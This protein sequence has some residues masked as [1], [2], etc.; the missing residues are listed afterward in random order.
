MGFRLRGLCLLIA[1]ANVAVLQGIQSVGGGQRGGVAQFYVSD[2]SFIALSSVDEED[3]QE[4]AAE[5]NKRQLGGRRYPLSQQGR[6]AND[7]QIDQ[8]AADGL[9]IDEETTPA[10]TDLSGDV[11]ET[12]PASTETSVQEATAA[13]TQPS[14]DAQETTPAAATE[15]SGDVVSVATTTAGLTTAPS[16]S[17]VTAETTAATSPP[18]DDTA[19][20][21]AHASTTSGS[22]AL[23]AF[24]AFETST[25]AASVADSAAEDITTWPPMTTSPEMDLL[26]AVGSLEAAL[27]PTTTEQLLP[28]GGNNLTN[29]QQTHAGWDS[30]DSRSEE[31]TGTTPIGYSQTPTRE[32]KVLSVQ[33]V[34][35]TELKATAAKGDT[36]IHVVDPD[37]FALYDSITVGGEANTINRLV[38][39]LF[40]LSV[41]LSQAFPQGTM[42]IKADSFGEVVIVKIELQNL[43]YAALSTQTD[44]MDR[45][46]DALRDVAAQE[47]GLGRQSVDVHVLA[48][49]L[50]SV[51]LAEAKVAIPIGID[52]FD[53][54][55][56]LASAADLNAAV[57]H[58]VNNIS[59][60][61]VAAVENVRVVSV[62]IDKSSSDD[63]EHRATSTKPPP[64][65]GP[66]VVA[67]FLTTRAASGSSDVFVESTSGFHV[68]DDV[69]IGGERNQ[70]EASAASSTS[71]L[72]QGGLGQSV[73]HLKDALNNSHDAGTVVTNVKRKWQDGEFYSKWDF[74]Y[75]FCGGYEEAAPCETNDFYEAWGSAEELKESKQLCSTSLTQPASHCARITVESTWGCKAGDVVTIGDERHIVEAVI[76]D[77]VITLGTPTLKDWSVGTEVHPANESDPASLLQPDAAVEPHAT[78][79][80]RKAEIAATTQRQ[81]SRT[82][83]SHDSMGSKQRRE[84]RSQNKGRRKWLDGEYYT[85]DQ[86]AIKL[87][88]GQDPA[89]AAAAATA[90][91]E[92]EEAWK[93][94]EREVCLAVL[95]EEAPVGTRGVKV[96]KRGGCFQVGDVVLLGGE[97]HT[98]ADVK[99]DM[100]TFQ[101]VLQAGHQ[102]AST[103]R[104]YAETAAPINA[105]PAGWMQYVD[106]RS[107]RP[108]YVNEE[109]ERRQWTRPQTS[110]PSSLLAESSTAILH[111]RLQQR[112]GLLL[113]FASPDVNMSHVTYKNS[114]VG[115][116][117]DKRR[118]AEDTYLDRASF[119]E[120]YKAE[121][122]AAMGQEVD[123]ILEADFWYTWAT[124]EMLPEVYRTNTSWLS[125]QTRTES[126]ALQESWA[127]LMAGD[128]T[129]EGWFRI[130][131]PPEHGGTLMGS[132]GDGSSSSHLGTNHRR[133]HGSLF[134][135]PDGTIML[136]SNAGR[137]DAD[138]EDYGEDM[139]TIPGPL[140]SDHN[141]HHFAVAW[142]K[143]E[144]KG[145]LYV[146]S[147]LMGSVLYDFEAFPEDLV[148]MDGRL[149]FGGG[150]GLSLDADI[151]QLRLWNRAL[152]TGQLA[153]CR[154]YKPREG[155][156]ALY[157][158][159]GSFRN[160]AGTALNS[161]DDAADSAGGRFVDMISADRCTEDL[162][163]KVLG[164]SNSEACPENTSRIDGDS[165]CAA[166]AL[167]L[168]VQ[169]DGVAENAS[170]PSGCSFLTQGNGSVIFNLAMGSP[171]P[172]YRPICRKRPASALDSEPCDDTEAM[173]GAQVQAMNVAEHCLQADAAGR[174][175]VLVP[176]DVRERS[177]LLDFSGCQLEPNVQHAEK[178]RGRI[179][180]GPKL[181]HCLSVPT[182][183]VGNS[184]EASIPIFKKCS[185][186]DSAQEFFL[187]GSG[188]A[189][190]VGRIRSAWSPTKCLQIVEG[191][192]SSTGRRLPLR[193]ALADCLESSERQFR[194]EL[195][196]WEQKAEETAQ[197][198]QLAQ[199][200]EQEA[201]VRVPLTEAYLQRA[202][203]GMRRQLR[204]A[205]EVEGNLKASEMTLVRK[206][207]ELSALRL[208]AV[209][210]EMA[211]Q[212]NQTRKSVAEARLTHVLGE[213][214]KMPK[215]VMTARHEAADAERQVNSTAARVLLAQERRK[216]ASH[217]LERLQGV[218]NAVN[219]LTVQ[220]PRQKLE[221]AKR[222]LVA[223]RA[224]LL[225]ADRG[226]LKLQES[227]RCHANGAAGY[228]LA[229]V[230]GDLR[231]NAQLACESVY[232]VG[233]CGVA[234]CGACDGKAFHGLGQS[235]V[236]CNG[237]TMWNFANNLPTLGCQWRSCEEV[238]ISEDGRTWSSSCEER[239]SFVD[240]KPYAR[241]TLGTCEAV[242]AVMATAI[243][244]AADVAKSAHETAKASFE[245]AKAA[246]ETWESEYQGKK[247][248]EAQELPEAEA[249]MRHA[250][251]ALL[252]A[253][254]AHEEAT[255]RA[256][257]L[258]SK[259]VTDDALEATQLASRLSKEAAA[260]AVAM[261]KGE[262]WEMSMLAQEEVLPHALELAEEQVSFANRTF[263]EAQAAHE[264]VLEALDALKRKD[265]YE[266]ENATHGWRLAK[267]EHSFEEARDAAFKTSRAYIDAMY[268][269]DVTDREL[270]LLHAEA[271]R[272]STNAT[273][274]RLRYNQLFHI[275]EDLEC[276]S[277]PPGGGTDEERC[278]G[279]ATPEYRYIFSAK[280]SANCPG[281]KGCS[282]LRR[283]QASQCLAPN[284]ASLIEEDMPKSEAC[285]EGPILQHGT[286]CTT[287]CAWGYT[288]SVASL[289]CG[290][291][292]LTPSL[293]ECKGNPCNAPNGIENAAAQ[294]CAEG[295][296]V[297]HGA[298]CTPQCAAGYTASEEYLLCNGSQLEPR[299]YACV[300]NTCGEP[301][302]AAGGAIEHQAAEGPC[303]E[304]ATIASGGQCTARCEPGYHPSRDVLHCL[305]GLLTPAQFVCE[306]DA[307]HAPE[308]I[309]HVAAAGACLEGSSVEEVCTAQC[310]PNYSPS[311]KS[312]KCQGG[313]LE[314]ATFECV[315][316]TCLAPENISD[317]ASVACVEGSTLPHN[318]RC[319]PKCAEGFEA[320]EA[321][322]SCDLGVLSPSSFECAP[323]ACMPPSAAD[324]EHLAPGGACAEGQRIPSGEHCTPICEVGYTP[325]VVPLVCFAGVLSP[326]FSCLPDPC[327]PPSDIEHVAVEG[328]CAEGSSLPNGTCTAQC[329]PGYAPTPP[330]LKCGAGKLE[331]ATFV[332]EEGPCKAPD[333]ERAALDGA[334]LEGDTIASGGTCT[335]ACERGRHPV[336]EV[337]ECSAGKLSGEGAPNG[338]FK[339]EADPCTPDAV[340]GAS[341]SGVCS[342]GDLIP[343]GSSCTLQCAAGREPAQDSYLCESGNFT[344]KFECKV[345]PCAA[346]AGVEDAFILGACEEGESI[347][348]GGTCTAQCMG[349]LIAAPA[350]LTCMEGVL[351]P[352]TF[353]CKVPTFT[354]RGPFTDG[355]VE[356][357]GATGCET[358]DHGVD[359]LSNCKAK[360]VDDADCHSVDWSPLGCRRSSLARDSAKEAGAWHQGEEGQYPY[361]HWVKEVAICSVL[362]HADGYLDCDRL[363]GCKSEQ[364]LAKTYQE[365]RSLCC[366]DYSC[367]SF[368]YHN[369]S[370]SCITKTKGME[371][372]KFGGVWHPPTPD[373]GGHW[374]KTL[375]VSPQELAE[376]QAK[377]DGAKSIIE[378]AYTA[379]EESVRDH[380]EAE[381]A[382]RDSEKEAAKAEADGLD[383]DA[384][385]LAQ[386]TARQQSKKTQA[387]KK[388][389]EEKEGELKETKEQQEAIIR[390]VEQAKTDRAVFEN[391]TKECRLLLTEDAKG[392][393]TKLMVEAP[394]GSGGLAC[395]K[396]GS[397]VRIGSD[398]KA[399]SN[400]IVNFGSI[401]LSN[402]LLHDH[403]VGT[404][405]VL[406]ETVQVA[407]KLMHRWLILAAEDGFIG[408]SGATAAG[409]SSCNGTSHGGRSLEDCKALCIEDAT[410][411]S[412]DW[413]E[414]DCKTH[415]ITIGVAKSSGWWVEKDLS[416]R[417]GSHWEIEVACELFPAK[418]TANHWAASENVYRFNG[419]GSPGDESQFNLAYFG[420][421]LVD[422][423]LTVR[424][425]FLGEQAGILMRASAS[426]EYYYACMLDSRNSS[427]LTLM[428]SG[429]EVLASSSSSRK[430]TAENSDIYLTMRSQGPLLSCSVDSSVLEQ[431]VDDE[432]AEGSFGLV[433]RNA[434]ATFTVVSGGASRCKEKEE[435]TPT[436]SAPTGTTSYEG[437]A[438]VLP[439]L[440][441]EEG[442]QPTGSVEELSVLTRDQE[443]LS[444]RLLLEEAVR[445]QEE[446]RLQEEKRAFANQCAGWSPAA[447]RYKDMGWCCDRW[448]LTAEWC[449]VGSGYRGRGAEF[450]R[451]STD[452]QGKFMA[453][454]SAEEQRAGCQ[455][456]RS[457]GTHP[458]AAAERLSVVD[459]TSLLQ[460][461]E[462]ETSAMEQTEEHNDSASN[463]A[464]AAEG[465]NVTTCNG[466]SASEGEWKG[467]GESCAFWGWSIK[468]C[469]VDESYSGY[470]HEFV[471]P[472]AIA[473]GKFYAPCASVES[474]P[475]VQNV[476]EVERRTRE[477]EATQ[478]LLEQAQ[479][480]ALQAQSAQQAAAE[481]LEAYEK[482]QAEH[483][484]E[485]AELQKELAEATADAA[486]NTVDAMAEEAASA[487]VVDES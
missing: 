403:S 106:D 337:L 167:D 400:Q 159:D 364:H 378:K 399:E 441:T 173:V 237:A 299:K 232:G 231:R 324:V 37:A 228:Y 182:R 254:F 190:M 386:A 210:W 446:G 450:M 148:V 292:E 330:M 212:S 449:W 352:P 305:A 380:L 317:A 282:C 413:S 219:L 49:G 411:R 164:D 249:E 425:N 154:L 390:E 475:I 213:L 298:K 43:M 311:V 361:G 326:S 365:C 44:I 412:I 351:F 80:K 88:A 197:K 240:V 281:D 432:F 191:A 150:G 51:V 54:E 21:V 127:E 134:L 424:V 104:L 145:H 394:E 160:L 175:L 73:M 179:R 464:S 4:V 48:T 162:M 149:D 207:H 368:E 93:A 61:E 181:E 476:L 172:W 371:D 336:P 440:S 53:V 269:K 85:K 234:A 19:E 187:S 184:T 216:N 426:S 169:Y 457:G 428:K 329:E 241:N 468:W 124:A 296:A 362:D 461:T 205:S 107:G 272:G 484:L 157:T 333:V 280:A 290:N 94:A 437:A 68:G 418:S 273:M 193:I 465:Q 353:A 17:S 236:A 78:R 183:L 294:A 189:A 188:G 348:N 483:R 71:S 202:V 451:E 115:R 310:A 130:G 293:F 439:T 77:D 469:Y 445:R 42:V 133:R 346:P 97:K 370:R 359:T 384:V 238:L 27:M 406:D 113:S 76:G 429:H 284:L 11:R 209:A 153:A 75:K 265:G 297:P 360:C 247:E 345:V 229:E 339:C 140:V 487:S 274:E 347:R 262:L 427:G 122:E 103:L 271:A 482:K 226:M 63:Q 50:P 392:G 420:P 239:S 227:A 18:A 12:T 108:Y 438:A 72:L 121:R 276:A 62:S 102:R 264:T 100:L 354:M 456:M 256:A 243:T 120:R 391:S 211:A 112:S 143:Q 45:L 46:V 31:D 206:K 366:A 125:L 444:A 481:R 131:T 388:L 24:A 151:S 443:P 291:G 170:I 313:Q 355:Y 398:L 95:E 165:D 377:I 15:L 26:E 59:G 258:R 472:S 363:R 253:T 32:P 442:Q 177:Q 246:A 96:S 349:E 83:P 312:L 279:Q 204:Q 147:V 322:L 453:P 69:D 79:R 323:A 99:D 201:K 477:S 144:R 136:A 35:Q 289:S 152:G 10:S 67:T 288:P 383:S 381:K 331:P 1:A 373:R 344:A 9:E 138:W 463:S 118:Y 270:A 315:G 185:E 28:A 307:C 141:W 221:E 318:G 375:E 356:C 462:N 401:I 431:A 474:M 171:S 332:C 82:S 473:A 30:E 60:I 166:M 306:S 372:G 396:I 275:T 235:Q 327:Q 40:V 478:Q 195:Q 208:K 248:E 168:D 194:S 14:G 114:T 350:V 263:T 455:A 101:E 244:S 47:S 434:A 309:S 470:G 3:G 7:L 376:E 374:E 395:F 471:Q 408:C 90:E 135:R 341:S 225:E 65:S 142:S 22:D 267:P 486:A 460:R 436:T 34:P 319:T 342:E 128:M 458:A 316:A 123:E 252:T 174:N 447:G 285:L 328:A 480:E 20:S 301:K 13:A 358:T 379:W 334:C 155:L 245:K 215:A 287:A 139:S 302:F 255:K 260:A 111:E 325:S 479:V 295:A 52:V 92:L 217:R 402:P 452:F 203:S 161:L 137:K 56:M 454:C 129:W 58:A 304:G 110:S 283:R 335:A 338:I 357:N 435:N 321:G 180:W 119:F 23:E 409:S 6:R 25:A 343:S 286:A 257:L 422:G 485:E 5:T 64:P 146:D 367:K 199:T 81:T 259:V 433:T 109:Q 320:S 242:P 163:S 233:R 251:E 369:S 405:V 340:D 417:S 41:P 86:F 186:S 57:E 220:H 410:C 385:Q 382:A 91:E 218:E 448:G 261:Q 222:D 416:L 84:Q 74:W 250:E 230:Q 415:S 414:D 277:L 158:L 117:I 8:G 214:D 33:Q 407:K 278:L 132:Y 87:S 98:L 70:L 303:T 178:C 29:T 89:A 266:E 308:D 66:V 55:T 156:V 300:P 421:T 126:G 459:S 223:A 38:E 198:L 2:N 176:C 16:S 39:D 430:G 419:T 314:P 389:M 200:A 105:L 467:F 387:A 466:W 192:D 268:W 116:T 36:Q 196:K 404:A 423:E 393:E 224:R 397:T